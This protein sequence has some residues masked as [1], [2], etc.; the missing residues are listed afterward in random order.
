MPR[1]YRTMKKDQDDLPTEEPTA[2]GLGVRVGT[3]IRVD[4]AGNVVLDGSGM[5][6]APAWRALQPY[7]IPR[8]LR[9]LV[10]AAR[11][12]DDTFCFAMGDGHFLR[13]PLAQGLE[14]IPDAPTHGSVAPAQVVPL[15][16]YQADISATRGS[17]QVDEA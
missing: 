13:G 10:H 9:A 4:Q 16:Q 5:S 2:A 6:V 8:R 14:L 3:D 17:W 12:R 15:A 7:R 1:V 11:G